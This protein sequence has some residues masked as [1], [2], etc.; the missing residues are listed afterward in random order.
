MAD[1]A[2]PKRPQ[3]RIPLADAKAAFLE[4]LREFDPEAAESLGNSYDEAVAG[5]FPASDPTGE[6]HND[7][8]GKPRRADTVVEERHP[9][10]V[11]LTLG[12]APRRNWTMGAS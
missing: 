3:D 1:I 11:T 9:R 4:S 7:D 2:G 5:T 10:P 8:R 6:E 12:G